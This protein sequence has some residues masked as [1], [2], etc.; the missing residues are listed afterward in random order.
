MAETKAAISRGALADELVGSA[1]IAANNTVGSLIR[2]YAILADYDRGQLDLFVTVAAVFLAVRALR[3]EQISGDEEAQLIRAVAR[4]LSGWNSQALD[5]FDD[6]KDFYDRT[7]TVLA[8]A[9][10]GDPRYASGDA[11]GSWIVWN[12]LGRAPS[13][14]EERSLVR[15]IGLPLAQFSDWWRTMRAQHI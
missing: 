9:S 1:R 2:R 8:E 12:I 7:A 13:S 15:D 11:V 6:C 5:G 14:N 3:A 10:G 4:N